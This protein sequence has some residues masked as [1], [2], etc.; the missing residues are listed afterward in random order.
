MAHG[1][2]GGKYCPEPRPDVVNRPLLMSIS[3]PLRSKAASAERLIVEATRPPTAIAG[4]SSYWGAGCLGLDTPH[5]RGDR[6]RD[7]KVVQMTPDADKSVDFAWDRGRRGQT[8]RTGTRNAGTSGQ[9][10]SSWEDTGC[11]GTQPAFL[12]PRFPT[13]SSEYGGPT[14]G[15]ATGS[16]TPAA[17][18]DD[19]PPPRWWLQGCGDAPVYEPDEVW[20]GPD[21]AKPAIVRPNRVKLR[22]EE[23]TF[24]S[25]CVMPRQSSRNLVSSRPFDVLPV[26]A[27]DAN[28][29]RKEDCCWI[30]L[31]KKDRNCAEDASL[32]VSECLD[33]KRTTPPQSPTSSPGKNF[34]SDRR[35]ANLV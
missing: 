8:N 28:A 4:E 2:P 20:A 10:R 14:G 21:H 12:C 9:F 27:V 18:V 13:M 7:G 24:D 22:F 29:R 5:A 25:D 31:G 15:G 3:T 19:T 30:P 23:A 26:D 35:Q 16:R 33:P 17:S 34:R 1:E 32:L 11:V 6:F